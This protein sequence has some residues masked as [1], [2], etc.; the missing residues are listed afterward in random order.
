[1]PPPTRPR[2]LLLTKPTQPSFRY[3]PSRFWNFP[4]SGGLIVL[5]LNIYSVLGCSAQYRHHKGEV[6]L[7][8]KNVPT[9]KIEYKRGPRF[10]LRVHTK[11]TY[12]YIWNSVFNKDK[13]RILT[14]RCILSTPTI[15]SQPIFTY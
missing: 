14:T 7:I 4:K 12:N 15:P 8:A 5:L 3:T 13:C 10:R 1:M 9:T 11:N 2:N 6:K